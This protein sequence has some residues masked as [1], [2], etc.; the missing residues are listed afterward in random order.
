MSGPPKP[1]DGGARAAEG[2][3]EIYLEFIPVGNAVKVV[4]VDSVSGLE[5]SIV[6]PANAP[7]R[8]LEQNAIKKLEFMLAKL[9]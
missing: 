3:R 7:R 2:S 1:P 8:T 6:G 4:A 9:N 5:V